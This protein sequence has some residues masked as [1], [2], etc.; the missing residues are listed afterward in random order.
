MGRPSSPARPPSPPSGGSAPPRVLSPQA[1]D[2][3]ASALDPYYHP[4]RGQPPFDARPFNYQ[5]ATGDLLA[6]P[7]SRQHP[8]APG[9]LA[10]SLIDLRASDISDLKQQMRD[11]FSDNALYG[12]AANFGFADDGTFFV[13]DTY[14]P[15]ADVIAAL[16]TDVGGTQLRQSIPPMSPAT[17]RSF[18]PRQGDSASVALTDIFN[19]PPRLTRRLAKSSKPRFV[20][21]QLL[22]KIEETTY[23]SN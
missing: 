9:H 1:H 4:A 11:G 7:Y 2:P 23:I 10:I 8:L 13:G 21:S 17:A 14:A 3:H 12:P 16:P 5:Y 22:Q 15:S 19:A 18:E 6:S 20:T